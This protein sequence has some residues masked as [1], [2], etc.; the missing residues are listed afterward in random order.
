MLTRKDPVNWKLDPDSNFINKILDELAVPIEKH[1]R[2]LMDKKGLI[3]LDENYD[4]RAEYKFD[5]K[6]SMNENYERSKEFDKKAEIDYQLYSEKSS[7]NSILEDIRPIYDGIKMEEKREELFKN[8]RN[9]VK[10]VASI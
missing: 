6:L 10:N 3:I 4:P 9:K 8:I 5:S 1:Y 2:K 7:C